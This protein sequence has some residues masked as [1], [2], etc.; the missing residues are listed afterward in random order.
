[1]AV[2]VAT[3]QEQRVAAL[4]RVGRSGV[5]VVGRDRRAVVVGGH[6]V[7]RQA[8]PD[9]AVIGAKGDRLAQVVD[10]LG[11]AFRPVLGIGIAAQPRD[12]RGL[13]LVGRDAVDQFL[14]IGGAGF[15]QFLRLILLSGGG[16][17]GQ[18]QDKKC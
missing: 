15:G 17:G 10:R 3:D 11:V 1:M 9:E 14:A 13:P 5:G 7:L 6:Q 4:D 8:Q 12:Q 16:N 2:V 18:N